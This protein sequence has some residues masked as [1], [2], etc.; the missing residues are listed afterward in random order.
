[1]PPA[2]TSCF[3]GSTLLRG[4]MD[5]SGSLVSVNPFSKLIFIIF[6]G[7]CMAGSPYTMQVSRETNYDDLQK[8]VLKEMAPIL[9]DDILISS[10][11][12]G[13]RQFASLG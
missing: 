4:P 3:V 10:Q 12:K 13:V 7:F 11:P 2:P 9:H 8:L 1:M 6:G 5:V